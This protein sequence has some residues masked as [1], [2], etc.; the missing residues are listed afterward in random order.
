MTCALPAEGRAS[1]EAVAQL[2]ETVV[3]LRHLFRTLPTPVRLCF[4]TDAA[5]ARPAAPSA[6]VEALRRLLAAA[7]ASIGVPDVNFLDD[8]SEI[9]SS[10]ELLISRRLSRHLHRFHGWAAE[11]V[12]PARIDKLIRGFDAGAGEGH[13]TTREVLV[14]AGLHLSAF[15]SSR[16]DRPA[17]VLLLPCGL[18]FDLC[19]KWFGFL[20]QRFFVV[21][22]ETRGVFGHCPDFDCIRTDPDAQADDMV[23][24]MDSYGVEKAHLMGIC[25]G[26]VI[27]L[28]AAARFP[29]RV[30][31]L[32]LWYGD[33]NLSDPGLRTRHQQNFEW[34]MEA[35]AQGREPASDL[36]ESF[37][38]QATLAA[39]PDRIAHLA[40]V[41]YTNPESMFRYAKI[42]DALNKKSLLPLLSQIAVPS[43]VVTGDSDETTHRGGSAFVAGR[44]AGSELH[45]E[46]GGDHQKLFDLPQGSQDL[47]MRFIEAHS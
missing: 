39:I 43:L 18:P 24:V 17:V 12:S 41:P 27:A 26:A 1:K 21:S 29:S 31:S 44:I 25:G 7:C 33:Y 10:F 3:E 46:A 34:L 47:A 15:A 20:N 2:L 30:R 38:D 23:A 37:A 19:R 9:L 45:V 11:D 36:Q 5:A 42:N 14:E 8:G 4:F 40:L 22:W 16:R 32:G 13:A 6:G 35:A 28:C